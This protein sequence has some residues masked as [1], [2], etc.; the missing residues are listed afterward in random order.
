MKRPMRLFKS[1]AFVAIFPACGLVTPSGDV[2]TGNETTDTGGNTPAT[3][4]STGTTGGT[5]TDPTPVVGGTGSLALSGSQFTAH[6]GNTVYFA[7]LNNS[8]Q[9]VANTNTVVAQDGTFT[10]NFATGVD[11]SAHQLAYYADKNGNGFC[12]VDPTDH[13]W[14][15]AV[16]AGSASMAL[17]HNS[18]PQV[19]VCEEFGKFDLTFAGTAFTPHEGKTMYIGVVDAADS[20]LVGEVKH[21][22]IT[23]GNV[24]FSWPKLL[25]AGHAYNLAYFADLNGNATCDPKATDH[26]WLKAV[27]TVSG[28]VAATGVHND[29]QSEICTNLPTGALP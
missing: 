6:A 15:N 17:V 10:A 11:A 13:S 2:P 25:V 18:T 22:V 29:T 21:A 23:G 7:L 1:L 26:Q 16:P 20:S 24:N 12:N 9:V 8:N 4:S 5:I 19:P 27:P 3:V 28:N 14:I